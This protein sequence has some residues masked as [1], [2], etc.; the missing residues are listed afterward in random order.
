[1]ISKWKNNLAISG[2]AVTAK[3]TPNFTRVSLFGL[4]RGSRSVFEVRVAH[5]LVYSY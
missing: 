1:M 3:T 4:N 2:T 5:G